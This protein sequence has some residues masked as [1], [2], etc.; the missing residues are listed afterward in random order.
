MSRDA[1]QDFVDKAN[2][3]DVLRKRIDERLTKFLAATKC[4]AGVDSQQRERWRSVTT[5]TMWV[6]NQIDD[7]VAISAR[8]WLTLSEVGQLLDFMA[9][10]TLR[11]GESLASVAAWRSATTCQF[12]TSGLLTPKKG[13]IACFPCGDEGLLSYVFTAALYSLAAHIGVNLICRDPLETH[14]RQPSVGVPDPLAGLATR[15]LWPASR[16][17]LVAMLQTSPKSSRLPV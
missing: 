13:G 15:Q 14:G 6:P 10:G 12:E 5:T 2:A 3:L 8:D 7:Q 16:P 4:L 17:G 9:S 1:I 11:I